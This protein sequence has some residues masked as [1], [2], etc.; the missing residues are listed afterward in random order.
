MIFIAFNGISIRFGHKLNQI[1]T[2]QAVSDK[3]YTG[4]NMHPCHFGFFSREQHEID[5][6]QLAECLSGDDYIFLVGDSHAAFLGPT[7]AKSLTRYD[8]TLISF[9]KYGCLPVRGL[10]RKPFQSEFS[11]T[12][13]A[14]ND[15]IFKILKEH[16]A[17][18]V[19]S[20]RWRLAL[21]G[22]GYDN[23][24][25][26]RELGADVGPVYPVGDTNAGLLE[27]I[28]KE[29]K[30]LSSNSQLIIVDQIP[31]AGWNVPDLMI[32][33]SLF[34]D[35]QKVLDTSY[36][37]YLIENKIVLELMSNL[38]QFATVIPA[39]QIVCDTNSGR[40][41]NEMSGLPLYFDDDHPSDLLSG[42]IVER[43]E[44][45]LNDVRQTSMPP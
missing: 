21:S 19:I 10:L 20:T 39:A 36:Q 14:F 33:R 5:E 2:V 1:A 26:G 3:E 15:D 18:I 37:K 23:G 30:E 32:K 12:C 42:M 17:P 35:D 34:S 40:C 38:N 6:T 13:S 11:A 29:L 45:A 16:P 22:T 25:G 27:I 31:E 28:T 43:I 44:Y 7:L 4:K 24:E 9:T 8:I 41:L